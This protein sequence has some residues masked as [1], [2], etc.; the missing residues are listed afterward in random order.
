MLHLRDDGDIRLN[1][2]GVPARGL[3]PGDDAIRADSARPKVCDDRGTGGGHRFRDA[4]SNAF[5]RAG[6]EGNPAGEGTVHRRVPLSERDS[7][8]DDLALGDSE[9]M[10][11]HE[12][13]GQSS[14]VERS[15]DLDCHDGSALAL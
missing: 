9:V 6:N 5:G 2:E 7:E 14:P 4:S 8:V 11:H 1:C 13:I 3:D 10:L 12:G 15:V